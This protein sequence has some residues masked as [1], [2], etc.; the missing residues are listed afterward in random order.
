MTSPAED[1]AKKR[2]FLDAT[3]D[4][5]HVGVFERGLI[6]DPFCDEPLFTRLG[7]HIVIKKCSN[8]PDAETTTGAEEDLRAAPGGLTYR[9]VGL[10]PSTNVF[11]DTRLVCQA[12]L[13]SPATHARVGHGRG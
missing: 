5:I 7:V 4:F 8:D 12:V 11:F 9:S 3:A 1:G 13:S 6:S 2:V 10:S